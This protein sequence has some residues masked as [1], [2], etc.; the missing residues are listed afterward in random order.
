MM[1]ARIGCTNNSRGS[2]FTAGDRE[3]VTS[4]VISICS[5]ISTYR[6]NDGLWVEIHKYWLFISITYKYRYPACFISRAKY[7]STVQT[8][9]RRILYNTAQ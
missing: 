6:I 7:V 2:I 9:T 8:I 5:Q 3:K 1:F 4:V